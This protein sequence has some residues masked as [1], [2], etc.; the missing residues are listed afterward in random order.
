[1]GKK[2]IGLR[3]KVRELERDSSRAC[4]F[5]DSIIRNLL[6][7]VAVILSTIPLIGPLF[8][9]LGVAIVAVEAYFVYADDHG[10][11]VGDIFAGTQVVDNEPNDPEDE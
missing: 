4:L 5:K 6:F 1:V 7:A 8:F 2:L 3:V 10:I 9:L 11:R